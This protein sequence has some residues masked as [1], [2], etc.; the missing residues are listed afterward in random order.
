MIAHCMDIMD[1]RLLPQSPLHI[2]HLLNQPPSLPT[3]LLVSPVHFHLVILVA[4]RQPARP[5]LNSMMIS[6]SMATMVHQHRLQ[7]RLQNQRRNHHRLHFPLRLPPLRTLLPF[8]QVDR[9]L[10]QHQN[11]PADRRHNPRIQS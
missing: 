1:L 6:S 7:S 9:L 3:Y 11:L 5:L 4:D 8:Q 10:I 2:Q